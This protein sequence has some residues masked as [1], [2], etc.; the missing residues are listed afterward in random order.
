MA[1]LS[2]RQADKSTDKKEK[3]SRIEIDARNGIIK[4][5]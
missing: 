4:K 1:C 5:I 2:G 3:Y